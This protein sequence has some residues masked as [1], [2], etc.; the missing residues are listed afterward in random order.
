MG[1][2][3]QTVLDIPRRAD[4]SS[5]TKRSFLSWPAIVFAGAFSA[6]L[7][8]DRIAVDAD[9]YWHVASGR[10]IL[11]HKAIPTVD[12]FSYSMQGAP[13]TAHEWLSQLLLTFA[14]NAGGWSALSILIA[15]VFAGT[16]TLIARFLSRRL[17]PIHMLGATVLA[18][19]LLFTHLLARPHLLAWPLM[20]LWVGT[21]VDASE[22]R[23]RPP[24]LL[25]GVI[26]LWANMHLSYVLGIAI[27]CGIALDA[28]LHEEGWPNQFK[29]AKQWAIFLFAA[30]LCL[31]VNP[32][33][34]ESVLYTIDVMGMKSLSYVN[35]WKSAD[36]H[37]F[38]IV[39]FWI[40]LVFGLALSGRLKLSI[41]RV[42]LVLVLFY[43]ALKHQR[44]HSLLGL[45]TPFLFALP[46]AEGQRA[47][48][49]RE[50]QN[51]DSLD[52]FFQRLAG[53]AQI[54]GLVAVAVVVV[55]FSWFRLQYLPLVPPKNTA[56]VAALAAVDSLHVKGRVFNAYNFGGFLIYKNIP[57]LIDG[58]SDMYGDDFMD[59]MADAVLLQ[60]PGALEAM[61]DKQKATWTLLLPKGPSTQYL[62]RL[63][64]WKRVYSDSVAVV[65]VRRDALPASAR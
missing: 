20:A 30:G 16:L 35:E 40:V 60:K 9:T 15:L 59:E 61:L 39:I 49:V 52:Q 37:E 46:F 36:F 56:P 54:A 33:G 21:L 12:P 64:E 22:R 32:H 45:V 6:A 26:V 10:W 18:G 42:I 57:V 63:P 34:F 24:W 65:H 1:Q 62:D 25:L 47:Q 29:R 13:W 5:S 51:A 11:A 50:G 55:V 4:E 44:Y 2:A 53:R 7:I 3:N 48:P 14:Y 27:A 17:E 28:T 19:A 38:Q 58:R 31:L 43:M 23:V 41:S 8:S